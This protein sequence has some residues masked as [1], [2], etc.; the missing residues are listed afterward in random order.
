MFIAFGYVTNWR[1]DRIAM[2]KHT[3]HVAPNGAIII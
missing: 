3:R 1:S 2:Y